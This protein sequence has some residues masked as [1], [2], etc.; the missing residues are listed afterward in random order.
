MIQTEHPGQSEAVQ[1]AV[2]KVKKKI[3]LEVRETNTKTKQS[4]KTDGMLKGKGE[5]EGGV[6][7]SSLSLLQAWGF[8]W[9]S[10]SGSG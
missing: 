7:S 10:L 9:E 2:L 8:G 5:G 4:V 1:T 6:K 3:H